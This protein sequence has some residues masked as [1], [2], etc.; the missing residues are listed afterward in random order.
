MTN[1]LRAQQI[2]L[3]LPT[4]DS[5]VWVR[6]TIQTIV[7]DTSYQTIQTI[8]R[9]SSVHRRLS[10]FDTMTKTL[11]DQV[12]GDTFNISG[13]GLGVAISAFIKQWMLDD[14]PGTT[15]NAHGDIIKE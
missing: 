11:T 5:E 13:V 4:E 6:A 2:V 7:K 10:E 9:T 12:T 8:D 3:D 14:I 1:K 15:E